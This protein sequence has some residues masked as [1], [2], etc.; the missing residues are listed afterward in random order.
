MLN[1]STYAKTLAGI[2]ADLKLVASQGTAGTLVDA[3][4]RSRGGRDCESSGEEK[5]DG[6][7]LH[8]E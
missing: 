5:D 6:A 2:L 7:E 1:Q 4:I 3:K 8:L